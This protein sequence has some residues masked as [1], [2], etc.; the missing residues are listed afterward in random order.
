MNWTENRELIKCAFDRDGYLRI[1]QFF[2]L[3]EVENLSREIERY[4]ADVVFNRQFGDVYYEVS[5]QP[6]TIKQLLRMNRHDAYFAK[7]I[8]DERFVG[9]AELLLDS[10]VIDKNMQ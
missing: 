6:D 4:I 2:T 8:R 1:P 9:L 3:D 7:L 5:G 10:P